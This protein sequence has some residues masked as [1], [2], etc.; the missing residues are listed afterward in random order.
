M[1]VDRGQTWPVQYGAHERLVL[2]RQAKWDRRNLRPR[3]YWRLLR[4]DDANGTSGDNPFDEVVRAQRLYAP[5]IPVHIFLDPSGRQK[6]QRRGRVDTEGN[7]SFGWSRAEARRVGQLLGIVDDVAISPLSDEV[8]TAPLTFEEFERRGL[9]PGVSEDEP[10]YLPRPGD[11]FL[12]TRRLW[13][14]LQVTDRDYIGETDILV[15]WSGT[16]TIVMDDFVKPAEFNLPEPPTVVP[17]DVRTPEA[18][19]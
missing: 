12:H 16:C 15:V 7:G 2:R 14:V 3:W 18:L 6:G 1:T 8:R 5:P 4:E 10:L 19:G 17:P 11:V 9:V 13:E